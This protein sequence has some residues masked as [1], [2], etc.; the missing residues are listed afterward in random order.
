MRMLLLSVIVLTAGQVS[1]DDWWQS[2]ALP[3]KEGVAGSFAGVSHGAL[4]VAGGANFPGAKPWDGGKKVWYD[5]VFVLEQPNAVW[6]VAGRLPRLL[7]Y[8]VSVTHGDSVVCVGGSN[9]DGHYADSFCLEWKNGQ[10]HT[11]RLPSL[12]QTVANTSGAMVGDTLYIAGG[13][14]MPDSTITM[15]AA[16]KIDLASASPEWTAIDAWP[17]AARMLSVA[18]GQGDSFWMVGGTDL[19]TNGEGKVERRYLKD[20]FRYRPADGWQRIAEL[21]HPVVAAPSPAPT[22]ATGFYV[23]GGDDGSQIGVMP[24][25]HRGFLK[26]ILHYDMTKGTW[27]QV[28]QTPAPRVT[29]PCV[30]WGPAWV[31][32]SGEVRPAIRSPQVWSWTIG[33]N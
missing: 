33:Q 5:T 6:K 29:T 2:A 7:G 31:I 1:G 23:L 3:D 12:P 20:A 10:L 30:H 25:R 24:D 28:G 18:A 22:D 14:A 11:T 4:L 27:A 21:P 15:K 13:Q 9:A 8:G 32:P 19:I 17:G 16:W 26:Q